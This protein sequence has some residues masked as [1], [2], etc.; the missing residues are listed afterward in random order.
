MINIKDYLI[1][2]AAK[3][4]TEASSISNSFSPPSFSSPF[5]FDLCFTAA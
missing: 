1:F 5:Q 2:K 4:S 3:L